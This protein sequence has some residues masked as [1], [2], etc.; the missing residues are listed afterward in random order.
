MY[1]RRISI[2]QL[3]ESL[4]YNTSIQINLRTNS[5]EFSMSNIF[6]NSS[7]VFRFRQNL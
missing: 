3:S 6:S 4:T 1:E 2:F 5:E 7:Y